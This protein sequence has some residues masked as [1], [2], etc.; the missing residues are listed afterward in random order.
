M[1]HAPVAMSTYTRLATHSPAPSPAVMVSTDTEKARA[2]AGIS[3]TAMIATSRATTVDN[4]RENVW[5]T[6]RKTIPGARAAT[7]VKRQAPMTEAISTDRRPRRSA[8][9]TITSDSSTPTRTEASSVPWA[10]VPAPKSSAA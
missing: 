2:P 5:A 10:P 3:S 4:A 6:P 9:E 7:P 8:N 1:R